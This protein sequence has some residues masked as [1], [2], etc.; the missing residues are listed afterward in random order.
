MNEVQDN[1][2]RFDEYEAE[3]ERRI[4]AEERQELEYD[5]ADMHED[6]Y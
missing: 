1:F 4:R 2:D 6:E 3:Q 5:I